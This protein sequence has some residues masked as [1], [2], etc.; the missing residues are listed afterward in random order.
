MLL[1]KNK[2]IKERLHIHQI[3]PSESFSNL[4]QN[5][6]SNQHFFEVHQTDCFLNYVFLNFVHICDS[7]FIIHIAGLICLYYIWI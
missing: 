1:L 4:Y 3:Y 6:Y 5:S 2:Q 7:H